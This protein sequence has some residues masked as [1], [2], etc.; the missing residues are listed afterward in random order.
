LHGSGG[1]DATR[2]SNGGF[3]TPIGVTN[4]YTS[5]ELSAGATLSLSRVVSVYGEVGKV[6]SAGGD[7]KVRSSVQGSLGLRARW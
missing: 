7:T 6:F 3:D 4:S 5:A 2:F 1:S